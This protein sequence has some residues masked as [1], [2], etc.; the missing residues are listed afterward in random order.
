LC[1]KWV[2]FGARSNKCLDHKGNHVAEKIG[3]SAHSSAWKSVLRS[4]VSTDREKPQVTGIPRRFHPAQAGQLKSISWRCPLHILS[5]KRVT[6]ITESPSVQQ[7]NGK[8]THLEISVHLTFS[9]WRGATDYKLLNLETG[10]HDS[11][12]QRDNDLQ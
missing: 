7:I 9:L 2:T 10:I 12:G 5:G 11:P 3:A 8:S 6:V 4:G 1:V